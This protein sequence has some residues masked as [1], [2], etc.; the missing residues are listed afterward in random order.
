[1]GS[2]DAH[3][4]EQGSMIIGWLTRLAVSLS[5]LAIVLYDAGAV[6]VAHLRAMD[7]APAAAIAASTAWAQSP[8]HD[9]AAAVAAAKAFA[10][11]HGAQIVPGSIAIDPDGTV[12][13]RIT[14]TA[15]T[16]V[17]QHIG[18]LARFRTVTVDAT[19]RLVP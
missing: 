5:L 13:L 18:P 6:G 7:T 10:A 14:S 3:P 8:R 2:V 1:M 11:G 16:L 9:P 19:N 12:H 17:I 15:H 4:R